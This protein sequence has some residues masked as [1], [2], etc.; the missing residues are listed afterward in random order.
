MRD[1]ESIKA[2]AAPA[3]PNAA[4]CPHEDRPMKLVVILLGI[5]LIVLAGVYLLVPANALPAFVPGYDA[6][7]TR[8][9]FTHGVA[10]GVVG[11]VLLIVARFIRR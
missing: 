10:S 11:I 1:P 4:F 5:A 8:V 9:R 3:P 2:G 7:L 6:A